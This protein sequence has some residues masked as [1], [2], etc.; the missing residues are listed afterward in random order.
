[1][2]YQVLARKYRP[3]SFNEV[4]GQQHVLSSLERSLDN[5]R[6][7]HA[8][9]FTG[10]RGV[11]KTSLAR[12]LVKC[13]NCEKGVSST[14]CNSCNSCIAINEGR[15]V[16]LI[17]VDAAS[18]TKVEDTRD[19]LDNVQ[20]MPTVGRYKV[21]L[22]DEVHMLSMHSFN[23]LLKT[24]EEPPEHVKFLLATTDPKKLPI[25]VLS[26]CLQFHL[27][28]LTQ[29]EILKQL[30]KVLELEK[31]EYE[32]PA[33]DIIAR[34]A[35]G[36]VRDSLSLL[37]QAINYS[38][39]V[40]KSNHVASMLGIVEQSVVVELLGFILKKD[41]KNI[42]SLTKKIINNGRSGLGILVS[43]SEL[44]YSVQIYQSI[45]S[46][47]LESFANADLQKFTHIIHPEYCHLL[48]Q[49]A[50]KSKDDLLLASD[51]KIGLDM[52]LLRMIAFM[53]GQFSS[54]D[55]SQLEKI[56]IQDEVCDQPVELKKEFNTTEQHDGKLDWNDLVSKVGLKGVPKQIILNSLVKVYDGEILELSLNPVYHNMLTDQVQK[57]IQAELSLTLG[58]DVK[59]IFSEADGISS[60]KKELTPAEIDKNNTEKAIN[61]AYLDLSGNTV[62]KEI[63][64]S[65]NVKVEKSN[66][67]LT[68]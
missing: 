17:E 59:L 55:M 62:I 56:D 3:S 14:P 23:A 38:N 43:L 8:Y 25:T 12:L 9:L 34:A 22:I 6:L 57:R 19:I 66:I 32:L 46:S 30:K 29:S 11:G 1:M 13:L 49:I 53:P 35:S 61:K 64:N 18:R 63:C 52:A 68:K 15:F 37:D 21:Y 20:Y 26:R 60:K 24:L 54:R 5:G 2:S 42:F 45:G 47:P 51:E 7:H 16:D 28:N 33:L 31:I 50:L 4:V 41:V 27:K 36:S 10:T 67:F 48:Y 44:L 65:F 39:G 40:I 58:V